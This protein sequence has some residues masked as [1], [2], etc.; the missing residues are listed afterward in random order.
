[1]ANIRKRGSF[2]QA[3]VRKT[4]HPQQ[5]KTFK[6]KSDAVLWA[7]SVEVDIERSVLPQS[8]RSLKQI[9]VSSLIDKYLAEITPSKKSAQKETYRLKRIQRHRLARKTLSELLPRDIAN[10][11]DERL[12]KVGNQVV[13]HELNV[14]GHMFGLAIREWGIPLP[15]NPVELIQKPAPSKPRK[16]RLQHGELEALRD[17]ANGSRAEY[18]WPLV[19]LAMQTGMRRGEL[20]KAKW[21][22]LDLQARTLTLFGTKNGEDRTIPL[23]VRT[24]EI[25]SELP[26]SDERI[27]PIS[28]VAVRQ[29]WE[30]LRKRAGIDDLRFHDLRHEAISRFFEIGL[31]VPEVALISGHRDYRMLFR[32]T[33]L[34][35]ED[36][37][38]RLNAVESASM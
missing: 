18:L 8:A 1:M 29:A 6:N 24:T 27:F 38:V 32:Y 31:S 3:Q 25:L 37:V 20:L 23:T 11:R 7:K 33:H 15:N 19:E 36:V 17:A 13:R 28:P 21:R 14:L 35:A 2:W 12:S 30:R 16:R 4:G 9:M 34:R 26:R 5:T 22:D 10:Y